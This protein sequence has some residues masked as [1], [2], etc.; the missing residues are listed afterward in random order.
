MPVEF[1]TKVVTGGILAVVIF[2]V[3]ASIS[4]LSM[5]SND[6]ERRWV[7]HTHSV[8]EELAG[9]LDSAVRT[10][11]EQ[12]RFLWTGDEHYLAAYG[13]DQKRLKEQ[14]NDVRTLIADN[15]VQQ[16]SLD[17]LQI[18]LQ[19]LTAG[20]DQR[21]AIRK[22]RG[23]PAAIDSL[24][25]KQGWSALDDTRNLVSTMQAE[26][27]RLL[28]DRTAQVERSLTETK[29]SLIFANLLGLLFMIST[30]TIVRR[31]MNSRQI[32]E[33]KLVAANQELG[34]FTYSAAHD[35]RAPLRHLHGFANF[36][37][38]SWHAKLDEDGRRLLDKIL[39]SSQQMGQLLDDLLSFSRL[40]QLEF[41]RTR[42]N[43]RDV[44]DRVIQEL[45]PETQDRGVKWEIEDLP[46]IEGDPSLVHQVVLNLIANAVKYTRKRESACIAIGAQ[47]N[48]EVG[49]VTVFVRD[50][51]A[52]FEMQYAN[53]LFNVFQRLHRAEE[54]EGTGIGLAI[55]RRVVERHG[56]KAWAEG[57]LDKGATFCFSLPK[58]RQSDGQA[59]VHSVG[60]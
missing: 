51:G 28:R 32:A 52:G 27:L 50:N 19:E 24:G 22:E 2:A 14:F 41:R 48:S 39:K 56:G 23:E 25:Q 44:V 42:V 15:P 4:Y 26:E 17:H 12:R 11:S 59:R 55:V 21:M 5:E 29:V 58:W 60:R 46:E 53:K 35:L 20:M 3:I 30:A 43:L 40:G 9:L 7:V 31:E 54:F 8:L 47:Q 16:R 13:A 38:Q 49:L 33:K 18:A 45:Q 34:A 57:E 10:E 36:L 1:R 6:R 37:Q